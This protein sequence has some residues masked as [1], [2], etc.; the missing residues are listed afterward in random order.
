MQVPKTF[1]G[2]VKLFSEIA[3]IFLSSDDLEV[4]R[5]DLEV[6]P[7]VWCRSH[8]H[9]S[10][11]LRYLRCFNHLATPLNLEMTSRSSL[12]HHYM[13]AKSSLNHLSL[14]P[15]DMTGRLSNIAE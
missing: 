5:D 12:A 11:T 3:A 8:G 4:T 2:V 6:S 13:V 14:S 10:A 15:R 1:K 7:D 9:C